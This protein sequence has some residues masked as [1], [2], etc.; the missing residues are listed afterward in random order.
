MARDVMQIPI[1]FANS[2][3]I[4]KSTPD[5]IPLTAY[6]MLSNAQTDRENSVSV[7]KGFTRLNAGLPSPPY[8]SY[9][10]KDYAKRQWRY[11]ITDGQLYVAPIEDPADASVWPIA[12]HTDFGAVLGGE[13]LSSAFDPRALWT[14]FALEGTEMKSYVFLADGTCFLKH[15]G[16]LESA[17]RVGIPMPAN[18]IQSMSL[19][20]TP[21]QLIEE[22]EDYT[23][24]T[25]GNASTTSAP[26]YPSIWFYGAGLLSARWYYAK[27]TFVLNDDTETFCSSANLPHYI[28]SKRTAR[29]YWKPAKEVFENLELANPSAYGNYFDDA[30][31][32]IPPGA[33]ISRLIIHAGE[34]IDQ[35]QVI[36]T[37]PDG[38]TEEGPW[39]GGGRGDIYYFTLDFDEYITEF[40]GKFGDYIDS[41]T[42]V[43]NKRESQ[44]YGGDGGTTEYS[45]T[46]PEPTSTQGTSLV[47]FYGKTYSDEGDPTKYSSKLTML[48]FVVRH[49]TYDD[50]ATPPANAV[51]W[52]LYVGSS[53]DNVVKVNDDPIA[54]GTIYTEPS[55]GFEYSSIVAPMP[56]SGVL[57][58]DSS[59]ETA[60][61]LKI[62]LTG[63][64]KSGSAIKAF[65]NDIGYATVKDFGI[66]DPDESFK[67]SIKFADSESLDNCSRIRLKFVISDIPGD[68]GESYKYYAIADITDF[69]GYVAGSWQQAQLF[70][71]DFTLVNYSGGELDL[72]WDTISAVIIEVI[73]IDPATGGLTCNVSFDNL[74]YSPV[75]RLSGSNLQ[76]VYTFYNSKTDTE[77]DFSDPFAN[78]LGALNDESVALVFPPTPYTN[79]PMANPDK[80]RIYRMGGTLDQYQLVGEIDYVAGFG[81]TWTDNVGDESAGDQLE[82]DNQLPP[83][84]VEGVEIWDNRLW[85]WGGISLD[86]ISEPLNRL[87]FSKGTRIE[88]FPSDNYLYVGS[89]NEQIMRV[90]EHD[91]ELFVFTITK[92]YRIVGQDGDYRAQST[93]VNQ[94]L[95]NKFCACRGTR[96]LYM[97]A[98]DGIYEFPN[99]RKISEPIN[100]IFFGET[101]NGIEPVAVDREP[102]EAMGFSDGKLVF[103]YCAS[104]DTSVK[105][106]RMIVWDTLYERWGWRIYGAQNL[107]SEPETN[108]LIGGNL[109]QWYGIVP[110]EPVDVRRSGSY[111]MRL[112]NSNGDECI[113]ELGYPE[114]HGIPCIID[115][116][117]YDLGYPD[118]E[119]QFIELVVD[120]DTQGYPIILQA[121]FDGG[122]FEPIGIIQTSERQRIAFP[123]IMGEENSR[124]AVRMSVRIQFESDPNSES[125]TRIYK[126]VHRVLIEPP[127]HR[128]FVT[129]WDYAGS[130]GPK[131]F[132]QLWVEMD[133]FGHPLEKIEVQIDHVVAKTLTDNITA[134]GRQRFYYGLGID[135][136]G[137]LVRLKFFTDGD[138]EVKVYDFGFEILPEPPL[139]NSIQMPWGDNGFPYRKLWKHVEMDIDT[140]GRLIEFAF[141]LDN[142]ISETFQVAVNVR[143]KVVHSFTA[144]SFG[145]LGRLTVDIPALGTDGLPQGVR[146]YGTPNF[147]TDQRNPDITLADSFEQVLNYERKKVLKQLFYVVENPNSDVT[148]TIYV[149]NV[150]RDTFTIPLNGS[151]YP[152]YSVRRLD[153]PGGY[154]G[155]L[156]RFSFSSNQAFEIDWAHSGP[157]LRDVNTEESHRRPRME[158]PATY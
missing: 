153:F 127:R 21:D 33:R 60:N 102:A 104:T 122:E 53:A 88:H 117:E 81:F 155:K 56:N 80:I 47:G 32:T 51:G 23:Q 91:G 14:T 77:S 82:E 17:R 57:S 19:V 11:A 146:M 156:F 4:I 22:F 41:L 150:A 37:L 9:F 50:T 62:S 79:P 31:G 151:L 144:E 29:M 93:A 49:E 112:D 142:V 136:R 86:G 43:T 90:L 65:F 135:L 110:G 39:H 69:S 72:G 149:D 103:S 109:T 101:V 71:S 94:G 140:E 59:G 52:N 99:G 132:G 105:N 130:P 48:G 35:I 78:T 26:D 92:V 2:G 84:G 141:W 20:P 139:L 89:G 27:Y 58:N 8:S 87:R 66:H 40:K 106:D 138:W 75:G 73:T 111:P 6:K 54:L 108:F 100:Q 36:W 38:T 147:I 124:M 126:I 148:L 5:E 118:Q 157:V 152:K 74:W 61:A 114:T 137:T 16:G 44:Q 145:K 125:S 12:S 143:Q 55:A 1:T 113:N 123:L 28:Q 3:I 76:W 7:R 63:S 128:T 133:T 46:V 158:P 30:L 25:G 131:Y 120:A 115:T 107:F 45:L 116:K 119:K 154:K 68:T 98:Y 67:L 34:L 42:I 134:N 85:T 96:G 70:K 95:T 97:R 83:E 64:G 18:P 24:W 13:N 10:L 15:A 121:S 129:D